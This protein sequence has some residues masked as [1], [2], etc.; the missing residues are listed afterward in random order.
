L[1]RFYF[2]RQNPRH[3]G[4]TNRIGKYALVYI[5]SRDNSNLF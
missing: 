1:D 4:G 2:H 3:V 5:C